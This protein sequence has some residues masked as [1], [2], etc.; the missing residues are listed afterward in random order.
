MRISE[1]LDEAVAISVSR[2]NQ[3]VDKNRAILKR[4]IIAVLYL[5]HQE[6]AFR[7]HH[8]SAGSSGDKG[9]FVELDRSSFASRAPSISYN[10][11]GCVKDNSE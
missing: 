6:Q 7:G 3:Q 9:N 4:L 10:I 11:Y 5:G 2:H 1:A 8:E